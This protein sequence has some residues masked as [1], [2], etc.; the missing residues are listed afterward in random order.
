M[1]LHDLRMLSIAFFLLA[2]GLPVAVNAAAAGPA[3]QK[4]KQEA[5]AKGFLFETSH[6]EIVAKARK[7]GKARILTSLEVELN[8]PVAEAFKKK[9][10]FIDLRVEEISGTDTYQRPTMFLRVGTELRNMEMS[11]EFRRFR[12]GSKTDKC[13]NGS[14]CFNQSHHASQQTC[15]CRTPR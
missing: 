10:P 6:D 3:L 7:E 4:A 14:R 1:K 8:R 11:E 9:Y 2:L 15:S 12:I 13:P 5:E